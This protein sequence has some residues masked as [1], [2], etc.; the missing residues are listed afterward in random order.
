MQ[1]LIRL[2]IWCLLVP[3][4]TSVS[5]HAL[6][7]VEMREQIEAHI[8]D[9]HPHADAQ[10]WS[11]LGKSGGKI[12]RQMYSEARSTYEKIRVLESLASYDELEN[13]RFLKSVAESEK[14]I[15]LKARAMRSVGISRG[16]KEEKYF[17]NMSKNS[18]P[19]IQIEAK[20]VLDQIRMN[21]KVTHDA[22]KKNQEQ[23]QRVF[24]IEKDQ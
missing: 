19:R 9:R 12:L 14:K 23:P 15:I 16:L 6:S 8:K 18:D 2:R 17:I 11:S 4:M 21:R 5:A 7:D 10:F 20:K 13:T 1:N 24:R 22:K 3:L